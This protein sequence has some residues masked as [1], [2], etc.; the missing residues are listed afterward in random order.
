[1]SVAELFR[2]LSSQ[3]TE[4]TEKIQ[5]DV[6]EIKTDMAQDITKLRDE[7]KTLENNTNQMVEQTMK[8]VVSET[9]KTP[10]PD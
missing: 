1:M 2:L 8:V 3:N 4:N 6:N 10:G 9:K 7:F 5:R